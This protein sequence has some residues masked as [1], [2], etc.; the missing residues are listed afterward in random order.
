MI[1]S[2]SRRFEKTYE[3]RKGIQ[4]FYSND[5]E[6]KL[7]ID[8]SGLVSITASSEDMKSMCIT[9]GVTGNGAVK[10][11]KGLLECKEGTK[12]SIEIN[13]KE[14][15]SMSYKASMGK[16]YITG[17]YDELKKLVDKMKK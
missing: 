1:L 15:L 5:G 4:L 3:V 10:L 8:N 13:G 17:P 9:F 12:V 16:P 11:G 14:E 6:K 2:C 7:L